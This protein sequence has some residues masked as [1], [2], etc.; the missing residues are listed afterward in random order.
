MA[1]SQHQTSSFIGKAGLANTSLNVATLGILSGNI[2]DTSYVEL[3]L[4][5]LPLLGMNKS[6]V[7]FTTPRDSP[8]S[9]LHTLKSPVTMS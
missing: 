1:I 7:L 2:R 4:Y 3:G 5:W 9:G 6:C 8:S